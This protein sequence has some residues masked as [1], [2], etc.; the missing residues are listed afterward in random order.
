MRNKYISATM[1]EK[2]KSKTQMCCKSSVRPPLL[3]EYPG[4]SKTLFLI[5]NTTM[6]PH[7]R[8][9]PAHWQ[10]LFNLFLFLLLLLVLSTF[11]FLFVEQEYSPQAQVQFCRNIFSS[12]PKISS[13]ATLFFGFFCD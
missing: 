13:H 8:W 12:F 9:S 4:N 5:S 11:T 1:P 3:K 10:T 7:P 6:L 2:N